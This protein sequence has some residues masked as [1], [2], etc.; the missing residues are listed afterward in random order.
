MTLEE[1]GELF[2]A[3]VDYY[4]SFT[5][6]LKKMK[7]WHTMLKNVPLAQ[8][9]NNLEAF[10]SEPENKYPPHPGALMTKRT[11]VDRYYE[12]MRQ[13]GFE[14]I[15][16]LDRMRVGVAPPTDEQKRRVRELLG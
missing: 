2:D 15:E 7:S 12:N 8:A 1:I 16:N 5:A 3:I 4:P 6:D 10:A 11:D 9:I 14:Q 13:S